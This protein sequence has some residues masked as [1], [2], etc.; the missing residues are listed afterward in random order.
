MASYVFFRLV[1]ALIVV[2]GVATAV[3]LLARVLP[4]DP[5][6]VLVGETAAPMAREAMIEA[7]GLH[8]SLPEQWW[9][10]SH[11]LAHLDMGVS[12][13]SG[14]NVMS[15]LLE[16]LPASLALA[17]VALFLSVL[18]SLPLSIIAA[19]FYRSW[20]DRGVVCLSLLGL[21]MPNFWLG[22]VL[23]LLFA[24]QLG[25]FPVGGVA[26][27][28]SVLLPALT[29]STAMMAL[30]SR[31]LRASLLETVQSTYVLAARARGLSEWR[32]WLSHVMRNALL[33]ALTVFGLQVG[34]VLT[35]VVVVETVFAWP[36]LGLLLMDSIHNRD[37]PVVQGC[38]LFISAC[39]V[40]VNF[41]ID[42]G[43]C[44]LDPRVRLSE[45]PA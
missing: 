15:L 2:I 8:R 1:N 38:V 17:V 39:Y 32:V 31:M 45:K 43:Y 10:Y 25:W 42:I 21:S 14:E 9:I 20:V 11:R 40:S 4:G 13:R 7:L 6:D 5:V 37:Y 41:L 30:Q 34:S 22:P 28:S 18:F 23:I 26:G 12:L 36:G 35:G 27:L 19:R 16:R 33:P 44:L 29:L 3:F 24:Y